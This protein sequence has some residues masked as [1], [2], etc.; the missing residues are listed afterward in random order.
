VYSENSSPVPASLCVKK[1]DISSVSRCD[2]S[3][4]MLQDLYKKVRGVLNKLTP[5]KFSKLV[6]QVQALPIDTNERL[7]GVI[8]LVFEKVR[9]SCLWCWRNLNADTVMIKSDDNCIQL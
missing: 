3:N 6:S 7:Q 8:N 2:E 1:A 4:W 5:Q 9:H